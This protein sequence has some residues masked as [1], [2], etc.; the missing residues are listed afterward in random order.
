M[1]QAA[2]SIPMIRQTEHTAARML[3]GHR[4]APLKDGWLLVYENREEAPHDGLVDEL[5]I[6]MTADGDVR[7][8]ILRKGRRAGTWDLLAGN[9]DQELDV[10]LTW[11]AKVDA[12]VPFDPTPEQMAALQRVR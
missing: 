8:R 10:A 12:I 5:C 6:V 4:F 7:A 3:R 2:F 1:S 9:A 11:A